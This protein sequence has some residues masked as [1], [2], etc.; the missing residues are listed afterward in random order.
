MIAHPL[1]PGGSG[2]PSVQGMLDYSLVAPTLRMCAMPPT[3]ELRMDSHVGMAHVCAPKVYVFN[4]ICWNVHLTLHWALTKI[5]AAGSVLPL[6]IWIL[7]ISVV[8]FQLMKVVHFLPPHAMSTPNAV[9]LS[10]TK[11]TCSIILVV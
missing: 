4:I 8:Q 5:K 2:M 6:P 3:K 10:H 1:P 7:Q 11:K 9:Q